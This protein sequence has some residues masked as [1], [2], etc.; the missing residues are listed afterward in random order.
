MTSTD[1]GSELKG[2][3][4]IVTGA[5]S[6]IGA[7]VAKEFGAHGAHLCIHY[8]SNRAGAEDVVAAITAV[9]GKAIAIQGD[10]SR[11]GAPATLIAEAARSLG[12]LDLL[13]NNAGDMLERQPLDAVGDAD[14]DRMIDLNVRPTVRACAAAIPF[15]R[16]SRGAIINVTSVAAHSGASAGGNLYAAAKGFISTYTRGLARELAAD[17]I[18]VNGVAPGVIATPLHARRTPPA[19]FDKMPSLIPLGRVGTAD[20]CVGAF[21]FLA[22]ASMSGYLTGQIIEVNGGQYMA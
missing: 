9:G 18:R 8:N 19:I 12:G 21:L 22:C 16:A 10:L 14:L 20:D 11:R 5:S 17:G 7:A 3:R 4:I 6:G 1:L 2:R 15:V 13:I